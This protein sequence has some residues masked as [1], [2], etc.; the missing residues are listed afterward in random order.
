MKKTQKERE[1]KQPTKRM[2]SGHLQREQVSVLGVCPEPVQPTGEA[3]SASTPGEC[4]ES[5]QPVDSPNGQE[6]CL[7]TSRIGKGF[8]TCKV[9]V[10]AEKILEQPTQVDES[11]VD[12]AEKE[13]SAQ[14][15]I[16]EHKTDLHNFLVV[17]CVSEICT[18][19][20]KVTWKVTS[21]IG[22]K[23][24]F[25]PKIPAARL[26]WDRGKNLTMFG[27]GG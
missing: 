13:I 16:S 26:F 17:D 12:K 15:V 27:V 10:S 6:F 7:T 4:L 11:L 25:S 9:F 21:V 5:V 24:D 8:E 14:I 19:V 20:Q 2:H 1:R 22:Q 23:K 3:V 18:I